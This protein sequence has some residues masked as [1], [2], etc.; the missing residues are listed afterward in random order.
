MAKLA[1]AQYAQSN[2]L[3]ARMMER[4]R[5]FVAKIIR[6]NEVLDKQFYIIIPISSLE[7]GLINDIDKNFQ[8]AVTLLMPRKDHVVRQMAR[9]GLKAEQL[10]TQ[11][12]IKLFY[13]FYNGQAAQDLTATLTAQMTAPAT[14]IKAVAPV[15]TPVATQPLSTPQVPPPPLPAAVNV[16]AQAS[17]SPPRPVHEATPFVVEELQ[18]DYS[19][20]I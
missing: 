17:I 13:D 8:K 4:Y 16:A 10:D 11:K 7:L 14:Q 20:T 12:L 6:E 18:D 19:A 1:Q 15:I 3:L 2:P 9:I 5:N